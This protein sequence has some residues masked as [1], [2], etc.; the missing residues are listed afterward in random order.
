MVE[1]SLFEWKQMSEASSP[2]KDTSHKASTPSLGENPET[3]VYDRFEMHFFNSVI[4]M[5][6]FIQG[7]QKQNSSKIKICIFVS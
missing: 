7:T 1:R 3:L 6:A 5:G 2:C 4:F